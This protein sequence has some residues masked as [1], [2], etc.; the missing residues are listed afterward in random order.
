MERLTNRIILLKEGAEKVSAGDY[1]FKLAPKGND[2]I[3]DLTKTFNKM[4]VELKTMRAELENQNIQLE[5]KVDERTKELIAAK[6]FSESVISTAASLVVGVDKEGDIFLANSAFIDII[7]YSN[8]ELV[9]SN[10]FGYF[11]HDAS[12]DSFRGFILDDNIGAAHFDCV[13]RTKKHGRRTISWEAAVITDEEGE[14]LV[15]SIGQD[16]TE[17]IRLQE[18]LRER[19]KE[20]ETFLY[21]VSHD[22]K[23]PTISLIGLLDMFEQDSLKD[24]DDNGRFYLDRI[25][26]NA[27]TINELLSG[28]LE[29][30]RIGKGK[31]TKTLIDT[32]DLINN[33]IKENELLI[34][35]K[36]IDVHVDNNMPAIRF[37]KIRLYQVFS[38]LIKNAI[39]FTQLNVEPEIR[40]GGDET[41][42]EYLFYIFDNGIG[43]DEEYHA[44]IFEMFSRLMEKEVE[45]TGI[46]LTIVQR[47]IKDNGGRVWL[48][49]RKGEGTTFYVAL[50]KEV[51]I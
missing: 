10:L 14:K 40:I 19:R 3:D 29:V 47:I 12:G 18:N 15:I 51:D 38:N 11:D 7:G 6:E 41:E 36:K 30:S 42:T 48:K 5:K 31:E 23:N 37:S 17:R 8:D 45:G 46:G 13:L 27:G 39:K 1:S 33:I 24:I 43:I 35:E 34:R 49:S 22:L 2:E 44:T 26:A 32:H 4:T 28:L 50:P 25:K 21:S 16:I 9:G 20:I